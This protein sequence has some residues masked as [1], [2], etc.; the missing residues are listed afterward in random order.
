MQALDQAVELG[1]QRFLIELPQNGQD[2]P[3]Q[4]KR[5]VEAGYAERVLS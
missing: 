2:R 5:L 1:K 4:L 3:E